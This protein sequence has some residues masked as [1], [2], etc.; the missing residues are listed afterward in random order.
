[1]KRVNMT[2]LSRQA[3]SVVQMAIESPVI[4]V[5]PSKVGG[6][7]IMSEAYYDSQKSL[8]KQLAKI[9]DGL[10]SGMSSEEISKEL[11]K[12]ISENKYK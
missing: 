11:K 8:I 10:M 1:M 2:Q 12:I 7:V 3:K 4:V 5:T 6:V 9:G